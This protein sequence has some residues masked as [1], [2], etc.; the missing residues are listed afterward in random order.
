[1]D[2][3]DIQRPVSKQPIPENAKKVFTGKIF[4]VYQW[5]QK[6][7]DGSTEIFEKIK[8]PDTVV[9]YPVL[10]DGTILLTEQEQPGRE[11]F[12][13]APSGRVDEGEDIVE[14]AKRELLEETGYVAK[15]LIFWKS[16]SPVTKIEWNCY[17]FIAKGC[18]KIQE[19]DIEAGE[20]ITL[21]PVTFEELLQISRDE[22]FR[23]QESI[24]DFMEAQLDTGKY[25][26]LKELFKPL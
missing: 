18:T 14:A 26:E 25:V 6:Q 24:L 19:Q 21:K 13:D 2:T 16:V 4:D 10:D 7:F 1:M 8:R 23:A 15:E 5:E 17:T 12:I 20:K 3:M 11:Q 22:R 9:V